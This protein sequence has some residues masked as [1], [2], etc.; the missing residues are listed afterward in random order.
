MRIGIPRKSGEC[1]HKRGPALQPTP[2]PIDSNLSNDRVR[3]GRTPFD[4]RAGTL[5][6]NHLADHAE[7]PGDGTCRDGLDPAGGS[8]RR[9]AVQPRPRCGSRCARPATSF[10]PVPPAATPPEG[11]PAH[12]PR[13]PLHRPTPE[14]AM[15]RLRDSRFSYCL[16][17]NI[18]GFY[19]LPS[20][21]AGMRAKMGADGLGTQNFTPAGLPGAARFASPKSCVQ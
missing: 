20:L 17:E 13:P 3:D 14:P 18:V 11:A 15:T 2:I 7:G 1:E 4:S 19:L 9:R 8:H 6:E 5:R 12:D 16:L 21:V 10:P